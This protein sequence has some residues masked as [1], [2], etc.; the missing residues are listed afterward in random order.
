MNKSQPTEEVLIKEF[1]KKSDELKEGLKKVPLTDECEWRAG[2]FSLCRK[3]GYGQ[4]PEDIALL[5]IMQLFRIRNEVDQ[6]FLVEIRYI[7]N[8]SNKKP[9]SKFYPYADIKRSISEILE[10]NN[11]GYHV[12]VGVNP[13]PQSK[14]KIQENIKDVIA[15]WAD[16]D[17]KNFDGDKEKTWKHISQFQIPAT[18]IVDSGNGYHAYWILEEPI[19][20]R[21]NKDS[22]ILKQIMTGLAKVLGG[23]AVHDFSR[24]MRLP[25]SLNLKDPQNPKPCTLKEINPDI[26]FSCEDFEV[27]QDF[28]FQGALNSNVN[29][30]DFGDRELIINEPEDIDDLMIS[31]RMKELILTKKHPGYPSRSEKDQAIITA[32]IGA[33]YNLETIK[34]IFLNPKINTSIRTLEEGIRS[35]SSLNHDTQKALGFV[36]TEREKPVQEKPQIKD[37]KINNTFLNKYMESVSNITD[38]PRLFILFAGLGLLSGLLNKFYFNYP[39]RTCLNLYIL[40]LAPST[41]Y[42]KSVTVDIAADYL[43]RTN[44]ELLFPESFTT[45][46]LL[47]ILQDQHRGLLRWSE[48]IQVKEF[49]F[50]SDYNRGLPSLL[51]D[52]FD[53]KK[54]IKRWTKKGKIEVEEPIISILAAGISSWLV[55]NLNQLDFQGG[56]WTRFI[57]VPVEEE[58]R[59]FR[60][61][62]EF[63]PDPEIEIILKDLNQ[64]EGS[65]M[66]LT[67]IL[68]LMEKWGQR[69][70]R[71]T[72]RLHNDIL[73]AN[74]QRLEI[75]LL[76][77]AC[78]L[79]LAENQSTTV[80]PE[81]FKE[82]VRII[83]Y[84]KEL[85]LPFFKEEIKFSKEDKAIARIKKLL[86]KGKF[87]KYRDIQQTTGFE[88]RVAK[89]ALERLEEDGIIKPETIKS[90]KKGGRP[91][92]AYRYIGE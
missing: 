5:F 56:I 90:T 51:T 55:Q 24:V 30:D 22:L 60:L 38:A 1:E 25:G 27:F 11:R 48:L 88:G 54:T 42:R 15:L 74:F 29:L 84:L 41:Y 50:G 31:K 3:L 40:L 12:Y 59:T 89:I 80:E 32:L 85:L 73:Q 69:H 36:G 86:R 53:Y 2:V 46:A 82:A 43:S 91:G 21:D 66:D 57:F 20:N 10:P 92:K 13:R 34:S 23:D 65:K 64:V 52:L 81:T 16:I 70:M 18:M 68:P 8:D 63:I 78:L 72:I 58:E 47:E 39:R 19:L 6:D 62:K 79:Q 44:P 87:L 17:A 14:E 75:M 4:P 71:Q 35:E 61:P 76:K 83:E 28:T 49:Q 77:I 9:F 67:N 7:S 45:E 37:L 26:L 33:G